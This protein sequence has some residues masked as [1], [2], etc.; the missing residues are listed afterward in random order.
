MTAVDAFAE[1]RVRL[2]QVQKVALGSFA[3]TR[4]ILGFS[5]AARIVPSGSAWHLGVLLLTDDAVLATGEVIRSREAVPRGYPAQSQRAR[6][7]RA[8]QA[9]RGGFPEGVT[10]H[11]DWYELDVDAVSR[12]HAS[13]PLLIREGTPVVRWSRVGAYM[14][15]RTYLD[16]RIELAL[17]GPAN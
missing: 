6:A 17:D 7:E 4:R 5:R 13:G 9:F 11:V 10:V 15:L 12:G 2:A 3:S 16:E 1:A 14:P 8:G